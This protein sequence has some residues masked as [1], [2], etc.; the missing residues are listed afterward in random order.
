MAAPDHQCVLEVDTTGPMD[1]V[2]WYDIWAA[3]V[4]VTGMCVRSGKT[5]KATGLGEL[6]RSNETYSRMTLTIVYR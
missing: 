3:A 2:S 4:A 5:G 6:R 1:N